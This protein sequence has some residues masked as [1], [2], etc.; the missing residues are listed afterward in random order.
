M[1]PRR[2]T[3]WSENLSGS[4]DLRA[5]LGAREPLLPGGGPPPFAYGSLRAALR[6]AR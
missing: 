3:G 1:L 4:A 5:D 2:L 6:A